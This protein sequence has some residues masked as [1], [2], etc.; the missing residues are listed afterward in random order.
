MNLKSDDILVVDDSRVVTD[1]LQLFL[2]SEGFSVNCCTDETLA[3]DMA[4]EKRYGI[5][6]VD[7]RMP[8]ING[9]DLVRRLRCIYPNALIIGY[10]IESKYQ[11]FLN[12]GADAFVAKEELVHKLIPTITYG[13]QQK[14]SKNN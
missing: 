8:M 10:S 6:L 14:C 7:F 5:F 3:L 1:S 11:A 13:L 4:K 12:A 2:E 9:D